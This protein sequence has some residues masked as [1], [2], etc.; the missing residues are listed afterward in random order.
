MTRV[1]S[2]ER[3][4]RAFSSDSSQTPHPMSGLMIPAFVPSYKDGWT[5]RQCTGAWREDM[6]ANHGHGRTEF[7][8][9]IIQRPVP[10]HEKACAFICVGVLRPNYS[11]W[12]T[13]LPNGSC[14]A[15]PD[16][17]LLCPKSQATMKKTSGMF[18]FFVFFHKL[19]SNESLS[20]A[21]KEGIPRVKPKDYVPA[22]RIKKLVLGAVPT[23]FHGE[24]PFGTSLSAAIMPLL[25][26]IKIHVHN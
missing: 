19:F 12:P 25:G 14:F 20:T 13:V 1:T 15:W 7:A 24:S 6:C 4:P 3:A 16:G 2:T 9:F 11:S 21:W 26:N 8:R 22:Y 10:S 23:V 5:T 18:F 17:L